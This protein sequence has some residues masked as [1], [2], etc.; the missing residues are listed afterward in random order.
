[1]SFPWVRLRAW[2]PLVFLIGALLLLG[3]GVAFEKSI[4]E[5]R[6]VLLDAR[7]TYLS[8]LTET[9]TQLA[10]LMGKIAADQGLLKSLKWNLNHSV[11]RTRC[12][13]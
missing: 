8:S 11:N 1:M 9:R 5:T 6:S 13:M 7:K 10:G 12:S 2:N 3:M 4:N